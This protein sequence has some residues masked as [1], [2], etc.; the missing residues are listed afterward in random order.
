M[1]TYTSNVGYNSIGKTYSGDGVLVNRRRLSDELAD[2]LKLPTAKVSVLITATAGMWLKGAIVHSGRVMKFGSKAPIPTFVDEVVMNNGELT[3]T[4]KDAL[5][6]CVSTAGTFYYDSANSL[7]YVHPANPTSRSFFDDT[8]QAKLTFYF[9]K[10]Q[11]KL[12][13]KFWEPLLVSAPDVSLRIE[14]RF[15]GVG[16]IGGGTLTLNNA[17][18][19]FDLLD[20]SIQWDAGKIVMEV[21]ID[22]AGGSGDMDESDYQTVGTW[23]IERTERRGTEFVLTL[24]EPKTSLENKIPHKEFTRAE[25]PNIEENLLGKPIPMAWGTLFGVSP[26]LI[27]KAAKKFKLADH[28]I[29]SIQEIR[30]Q[31]D[32]EGWV[33]VN[34]ATQNLD[35]AEFT[36]GAEW[37][38]EPVSVDFLGRKRPDGT[39]MENPA[40]VMQD[41]LNYCGESRLDATTFQL[42]REWFRMGSDRFGQEV[43]ELAPC[44]YLDDH[45]TG[46]DVAGE[47]NNIAG[48]FLFID[49][50]NNWRF[51]VFAPVRTQDLDPVAGS[52]IQ[53][54]S[55]QEIYEGSMSKTVDSAKLFSKLVVRYGERRTEG[56]APTVTH[57]IQRNQFIHNLAPQFVETKTIGVGKSGDAEY[58][59]QRFLTMDAEPLTKYSFTVPW[60]GLFLL[61][62]DKCQVSHSRHSLNSVL[63]TLEVH[64]NF[65]SPPSVRIVAGNLR[66]WG[67]TFGFWADE[68]SD[69]SIPQAGLHLWLAASDLQLSQ[70][71]TVQQWPDKS[72]RQN[73]ATQATLSKRPIYSGFSGPND[74]PAVSFAT[75]QYLDLPAFMAGKQAGEIFTVL[76]S[77][78]DPLTDVGSNVPYS[79]GNTGDDTTYPNAA[80]VIVESFGQ[81]N[82]QNTADPASSLVDAF[83]IYNA[84]VTPSN[85]SA[86][87]DGAALSS[88]ALAF[89]FGFTSPHYIGRGALVTSY[90]GGEICEII[91]Y[92][93][94]L[95]AAERSQVVQYLSDKYQLGLVAAGTSP[96]W[97]DS[98]T[99]AQVA[100]ARQ[101]RGYW[102]ALDGDDRETD[103]ADTDDPRSFWAGRL[104]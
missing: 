40:D 77:G 58:W 74:D 72:G 71:A 4:K 92:D 47:I 81:D 22:L 26:V 6:D 96:D 38:D 2:R 88:A 27:D 91:V 76:R 3:L 49:Y 82:G 68:G 103:M 54:F 46:L 101:N 16:H 15:G 50:Q 63:E 39:L 100:D 64:Y 78:G 14:S 5:A 60:Q 87:L 65:N 69:G 59:L 20:D 32:E 18:G 33:T 45:R 95:S 44:I 62:G 12:R 8:Y 73:N 90:F 43:T 85:L 104:L 21:G 35:R 56:W 37:T 30:I 57:E 51:G 10:T 84:A 19:Y 41:L 98:W 1:L 17:R 99:D 79:F 61:P 24:R 52:V 86:W 67:D 36:L 25:Y 93:R 94:V 48:T 80:G 55:E 23:R 53:Q 66:G 7:L 29:R 31:D 28:A 13:G 83:H 75:G 11:K 89:N 34:P 9:A 42:T 97:D 70:G 102:S